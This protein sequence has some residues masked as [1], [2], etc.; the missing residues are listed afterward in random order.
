MPTSPDGSSSAGAA[1]PSSP[2]VSP[3]GSRATRIDPAWAKASVTMEKPM[4]VTRRLTDPRTSAS[5]IPKPTPSSADT[6][7]G[8]PA[9]SRNVLVA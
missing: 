7:N 5:T 2:P 9:S 1:R 8:R 3:P 4:P 6:A